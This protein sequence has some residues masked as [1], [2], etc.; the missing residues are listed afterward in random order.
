MDTAPRPDENA[1]AG[2]VE[3]AEEKQRRLAWEAEAITQARASADAGRLIDEADIDAWI[4]S[5]GTDH[6]E[7]PIAPARG[8]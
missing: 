4:D 7:R 8:T 2:R 6:E 1:P 3:T 5:L